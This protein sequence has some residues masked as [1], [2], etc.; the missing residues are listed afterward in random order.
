L[1]PVSVRIIENEVTTSDTKIQKLKNCYLF[2][3][4]SNLIMVRKWTPVERRKYLGEKFFTKR[5]RIFVVI[6]CIL[7]LAL[8][9]YLTYF[10]YASGS[11]LFFVIFLVIIIVSIPVIIF[12]IDHVFYGAE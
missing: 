10:S 6:L 9:V 7:A 1:I 2:D 4:H 12:A 11:F 5:E 8:L 3:K